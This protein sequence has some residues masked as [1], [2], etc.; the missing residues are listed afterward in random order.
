MNNLHCLRVL[1]A[2]FCATVVDTFAA[3]QNPKA[4]KYKEVKLFACKVRH[5]FVNIDSHL[6]LYLKNNTLDLCCDLFDHGSNQS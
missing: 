5:I 2:S 1:F 6:S 3:E 4:E